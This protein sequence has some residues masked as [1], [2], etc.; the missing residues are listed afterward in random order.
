MNEP[1]EFWDVPPIPL[2]LFTMQLELSG[3]IKEF[4]YIDDMIFDNLYMSK[5]MRDC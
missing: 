5:E 1:I 2:E 3:R 4:F